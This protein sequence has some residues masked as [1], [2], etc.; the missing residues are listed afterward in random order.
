MAL[1]WLACMVFQTGNSLVP[2]LH[3]GPGNETKQVIGRSY[4]I[5][6]LNSYKSYRMLL[7]ALFVRAWR[8]Y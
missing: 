3:G 7:L 5:V 1:L 4:S 2:R 6:L 8:H